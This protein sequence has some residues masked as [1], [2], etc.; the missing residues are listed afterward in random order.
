METKMKK[1][2]L[3]PFTPYY[4][5][6]LYQTISDQ[7]QVIDNINKFLFPSNMIKPQL[8]GLAFTGQK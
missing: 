5:I 8:L 1:I 3:I 6:F 4:V 7:H 2:C